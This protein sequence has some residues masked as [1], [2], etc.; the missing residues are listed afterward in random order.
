VGVLGGGAVGGIFGYIV[1]GTTGAVV[2]GLAGAVAGGVAG[3]YVGQPSA[4]NTNVLPPGPYMLLGAAAKLQPGATYLLS[5]AVPA[6]ESSNLTAGVAELEKAGFP[7]LGAWDV[8]QT[9]AGWPTNDPNPQGIHVAIKNTSTT[10]EPTGS[11]VTTWAT[12][13]ASS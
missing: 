1:R 6:G 7:V 11:D 10:V 8:G 4:A 13:G 5:M 12:Q 3:S 2:G 9:P